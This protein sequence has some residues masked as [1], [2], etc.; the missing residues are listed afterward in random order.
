MSLFEWFSERYNTGPV[1][2]INDEED[3]WEP[4][5]K[6]TV[7]FLILL[8]IALLGFFVWSISQTDHLW[9]WT[10]AFLVYL[11]ISRF[12]SPRPDHTNMG[13]A[14]GLLDNPFRISDDHNRLLLF[15]AFALIPGKLILYAA[16]TILN[17]IRSL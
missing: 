13:W 2:D 1:G 17:T 8:G 3:S 15:F 14:R 12:A 10:L 16:Q 4:K 11:L 6:F 7:W 5:N 9:Q